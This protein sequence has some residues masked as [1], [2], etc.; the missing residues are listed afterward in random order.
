VTHVDTQPAPGVR[1]HLCGSASLGLVPGYSRLRRVTSDCKPWPAG[2]GLGMCAD[3]RLVQ[4]AVTP[5][6]EEEARKIYAGYTIYHQSGGVEQSVFASN[7]GR[8]SL[9]SSVIVKS[10]REHAGLPAQGRLLD[11]GCGNGAFLRAASAELAG[12]RLFGSEWDDKYRADVEAIPGFEQ[13]YTGDW[14]DIPGTFDV[15]SLVHV[16]EHIASPLPVLAMIRGKLA[17]GGLL[18]VEVPDCRVNP[19]MLLIAD[20]CSHFSVDGLAAVVA[21]AGFDIVQATNQWVQKEITVVARAARGAGGSQPVLPS[22]DASQITA[23]VE[24]LSAIAA[25]ARIVASQAAAFGIF[26]TSIAATWLDAELGDATRF[27]VDED[28]NRAGRQHAGK[29]ILP[30]SGIPEGSVV[31]VALPEP[32]AGQVAARLRRPGVEVVLP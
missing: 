26:G 22:D 11:L 29:P 8:G 13:L 28:P 17:S 15:I 31:F 16:L 12:W 30:P 7:D 14:K 10:L 19:Y 5:E 23:G 18:V 21:A 25:Q 32:L 6:W 3:C 1:C 24:K 27:F 4:S 2:G 20:H 9:R